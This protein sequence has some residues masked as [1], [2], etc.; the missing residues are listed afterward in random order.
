MAMGASGH[1]LI[2]LEHLA[3]N[4]RFALSNCV[5]KDSRVLSAH[6][7]FACRPT[8]RLHARPNVTSGMQQQQRC[9]R[10]HRLSRMKPRAQLANTVR[11]GG[12]DGMGG[13]R[14]SYDDGNDSAHAASNS[15]SAAGC[16]L[17]VWL[18]CRAPCTHSRTDSHKPQ[19]QPHNHFH[20]VCARLKH[21]QQSK[22]PNRD[23]VTRARTLT[24][25]LRQRTR[26]VDTTIPTFAVH[27][28]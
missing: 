11:V 28:R 21:V 24:H 26:M 9:R 8:A 3:S 18:N 10:C 13:T 16:P 23:T 27:Q 6:V 5:P 14:T 22:R 25:T 17:V 2:R 12:M 19:T 4:A 7:A 1:N 20:G 15:M